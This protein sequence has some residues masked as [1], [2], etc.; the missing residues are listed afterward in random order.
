MSQLEFKAFK[1][2]N[3]KVKLWS[4]A[5]LHNATE[6]DTRACYHFE[7][8]A[9]TS[10][11]VVVNLSLSVIR[12]QVKVLAFHPVQPWLAYADVSQGLTV[13]DWSNQQV[14]ES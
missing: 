7:T 12:V 3:A 2:A 9:M 10:D 11:L 4:I 14:Q 8:T 6:S 5:W 1:Q 13:W